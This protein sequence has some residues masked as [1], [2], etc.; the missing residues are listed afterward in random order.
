M[1]YFVE[2]T[3]AINYADDTNFHACDMD[4][5]NLI[6]RL[7]HDSAIVTELF[8]S[9][10]MKLNQDKCHLLVAGHKYEHISIDI[11]D[12]QIWESNS[13]KVLGVTID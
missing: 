11:G 10:H 4:L 13:E 3:E 9:N 5:G 7:E 12:S 8:E 2:E 6:R 1:F